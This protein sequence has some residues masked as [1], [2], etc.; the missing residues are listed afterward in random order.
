[1]F[2]NHLARQIAS[3]A[4]SMAA[5]VHDT[6]RTNNPALPQPQAPFMPQSPQPQLNNSTSVQGK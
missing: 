3:I 1:M 6:Q 5:Q 4:N 2:N